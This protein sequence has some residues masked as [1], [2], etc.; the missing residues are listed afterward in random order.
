MEPE[1]SHI[2]AFLICFELKRVL[3]PFS[4]SIHFFWS[5]VTIMALFCQPVTMCRWYI[6][7]E[8]IENAATCFKFAS[9]FSQ[10]IQKFLF[11][12]IF[13]RCCTPCASI[14]LGYFFFKKK[15]NLVKLILLVSYLGDFYILFL[16]FVEA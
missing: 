10:R 11:Y 2:M 4:I 15:T 8:E 7:Q 5:S 12:Q 6:V 3:C 9:P 1:S 16:K 14:L 13:Y